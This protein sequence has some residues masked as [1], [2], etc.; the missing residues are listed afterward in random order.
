MD[1]HQRT[2]DVTIHDLADSLGLSTTTVWRALNDQSRISDRTR[3]RVMDE[4]HRRG[5]RPSLVAR[6]LSSGKTQT[7]GLVLPSVANPTFAGLVQA[8]ED[9]AFER[10]YS[11]LLCNTG[12]DLARERR[13]VELLVQRQ[14][15]AVVIVPY[16]KR[17][18]AEDAHLTGLI[19]QGIP[20]V[21]MHHRMADMP[22]PQVVPDNRQG[23]FDSTIHL[24]GLGHKKIVF[25]H[26]GLSERLIPVF[27]RFEGFR[28][29][30]Q[31]HGLEARQAQVGPFDARLPAPGMSADVQA[32]LVRRIFTGKSA[33][34][35]L[36]AP[37]DLLAAQ[38]MHQAQGLGLN[39]PD[40]VAVVGFDD[41]PIAS[42]STPGL[43]SVRPSLGAIGRLAAEL[44]FEQID[45][46]ATDSHEAKVQALPCELVVR[47]STV[48]PEG[49]RRL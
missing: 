23:A 25:I 33:A 13:Q 8:V 26:T 49:N 37:S 21:A 5:Y 30:M 12:F 35:A 19:D 1:V 27:E 6:A 15:E 24:I 45:R 29:A 38:V 39:V 46:A 20:V 36:V 16:F 2:S 28:A 10:G 22:I 48:R 40:D 42:L 17:T 43:T 3:K 31:A 44:V 11:V 4:A 41:S 9:V 47:G 32:D 14:V 18:P 7:L 34:S